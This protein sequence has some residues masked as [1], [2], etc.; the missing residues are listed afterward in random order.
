MKG[1]SSTRALIES[2]L[3]TGITAI[4]VF[5]T[6]YFPF[7]MLVGLFIWPLPLAL[8]YIRNGA[9]YSILSLIIV[10]LIAIMTAGINGFLLVFTYGISGIVLGYCIDKKKSSTTTLVFMTIS[11]FITLSLAMKLF[12]LIT[13]LDMIAQSSQIMAQNLENMKITYSSMGVPSETIDQFKTAIDPKMMKMIMPAS[14]FFGAFM[15]SLLM[16]TFARMIFKRFKYEISPIKAF[17]EWYVPIAAAFSVISLVLISYALSYFKVK[18]A[19]TYLLNSVTLLK[20]VFT[21]SGLALAD[22]YLKKRDVSKALRILIY[23]FA[24]LPLNQIL[25]FAGIIDYAIDFRKLDPT[26]RRPTE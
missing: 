3:L 25:F 12:F 20:I 1:Q 13:G 6:L 2:A 18:N 19:D 17:S 11:A 22:F 14:L 21:I 26:R 23:F 4:L 10:A 16:Y 5:L 7:F 24:V 15:L 9:K 8:I